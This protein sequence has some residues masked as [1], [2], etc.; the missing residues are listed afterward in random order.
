MYPGTL[1]IGTCVITIGDNAFVSCTGF[2]GSLVIPNA[3][4]SIDNYSFYININDVIVATNMLSSTSDGSNVLGT[5]SSSSSTIL[6]SKEEGV[7]VATHAAILQI[8][9][10]YVSID[11][12]SSIIYI[13]NLLF[14]APRGG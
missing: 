13:F 4:T 10:K 14:Q 12:V 7:I 11:S 8:S 2:T 3:I 9:D 5:G 6:T 1:T